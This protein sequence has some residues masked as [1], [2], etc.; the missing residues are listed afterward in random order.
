MERQITLKLNKKQK[1]TKMTEEK[2]DENKNANIRNNNTQLKININCEPQRNQIKKNYIN[3]K[4][5]HK[6]KH[7]TTK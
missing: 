4:I 6:M 2:K 7:Q 1:T 5:K 3:Q